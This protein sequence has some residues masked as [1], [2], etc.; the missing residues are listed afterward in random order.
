MRYRRGNPFLFG[1]LPQTEFLFSHRL[2]DSAKT[3]GNALHFCRYHDEDHCRPR[4]RLLSPSE[5]GF[6]R[7]R[8]ETFSRT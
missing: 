1:R 3:F 5:A 7:E 4:L 8:I 6:Q 2:L